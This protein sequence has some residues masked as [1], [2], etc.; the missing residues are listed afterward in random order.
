MTTKKAPPPI[1]RFRGMLVWF[2]AEG[3][4]VRHGRVD[5]AVLRPKGFTVELT[6]GG[7]PYSVTLRPRDKGRFHGTWS[8]G[9]GARS[10]SGAAECRLSPCG[11]TIGEP[12]RANLKLE[13]SWH[14][15]VRWDWVARLQPIKPREATIRPRPRRLRPPS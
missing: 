12:G 15:D 1:R 2:D 4:R 13:G 10:T 14:E 6:T 11:E 9:A 8:R 5:R 7:Q 3:G